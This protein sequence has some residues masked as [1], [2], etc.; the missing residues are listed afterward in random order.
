MGCDDLIYNVLSYLERGVE[1]YPDRTALADSDRHFT[2]SEV[3]KTAASAGNALR[4][5]LGRCGM[6]VAVMLE[7][8]S[9]DIMAFLSVLFAGSF[10]VPVDPTLPLERISSIFRTMKP[11]AVIS[12]DTAADVPCSAPVFTVRE[13]AQFDAPSADAWRGCKDTDP[14]YVIFTSGSTG[15][16]KGVAVSHRSVIDMVEGFC[17]TFGFADGAVFGNQA[18]FDFDVSV[19]DIYISLAVGGTLEILE[20]RLFSFPG[21]LIDRLDERRVDTVIWAVPAMKIIASLNAFRDRV[22][23]LSRV[24]FSGELM[25]PK[26][27]EYWKEHLPDTAFVNLYGPTEITCNC[28]YYALSNGRDT[29]S[30]LPIGRAFPNCDVRL[31]DGDRMITDDGEVGEICV[32]GSCLALG[33]YNRP[34]E[35]AR[36]FVQDPTVAEY[37]ARMYRTGDL[38]YRTD[39]LLYFCGRADSQIKHMGHRIELSEIE[40][41]TMSTSGVECAACVFDESVPRII[42]YYVGDAEPASLRAELRGSLPRYMLPGKILKRTTLP[43]TRTGKVDRRALL[44]ESHRD[45]K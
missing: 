38:A 44:D 32:S 14:L 45:L 26:T 29:E 7:R 10:Y 3:W 19:K 12:P 18:P 6:P 40:L 41:R 28:T 17:D 37:P 13:L 25:P 2:Y 9:S 8:S 1:R 34:D 4:R 43:K 39:G 15:E 20:Q 35:T 36:A 11:A 27:L 33:Y 21:L 24:M 42:L 22:P 31:F 30:E 16:P 5:A 23:H